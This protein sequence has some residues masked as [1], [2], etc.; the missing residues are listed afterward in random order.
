MDKI[1]RAGTIGK[2]KDDLEAT[3]L[4]MQSW[5]KDKYQGESLISSSKAVVTKASVFIPGI[6][7]YIAC[8]FDVMKEKGVHETTLQ[9]KHRLF[10]DMVYGDLRR[11]D[12]LH[13]IRIDHYEM[14]EDVQKET[15]EKLEQSQDHLLELQGT[16]DFIDEFYHIHGFD[17]DNVNYDEDID[18][19]SFSFDHIDINIL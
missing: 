5:L 7:S 18:L 19:S 9:H 15:L 2:A 12:A 17:F 6:T 3:S 8:L 4:R 16:K 1:Y 14:Q 10:K 13:R 11:V